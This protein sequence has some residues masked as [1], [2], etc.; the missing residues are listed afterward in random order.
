MTITVKQPEQGFEMG[1]PVRG[2]YE[3][4]DAWVRVDGYFEDCQ[5][6]SVEWNDQTPYCRTCDAQWDAGSEEFVS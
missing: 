2:L 3:G 4:S 6:V 5:H 1:I